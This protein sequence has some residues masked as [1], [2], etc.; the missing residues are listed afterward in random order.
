MTIEHRPRV[1]AVS[2]PKNSGKTF[3]VEQL[4]A[5]LVARGLDVAV[6]KHDAHAHM[7]IDHE[8]KDSWRY[9]QAGAPRIGIIGPLGRVAM[10]YS[11]PFLKGQSAADAVASLFPGA[12]LILAEGFKDHPLPRIKLFATHEGPASH[13]AFRPEPARDEEIVE[14]ESVPLTLETCLGFI[15]SV[16]DGEAATA[17]QTNGRTES[18]ASHAE[19]PGG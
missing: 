17:P 5:A 11:E 15:D 16:L 3:L 10:D 9:R 12:A 1:L 4:I 18:H 13:I 14:S 19:T 6:V 2:G 7:K 8:G